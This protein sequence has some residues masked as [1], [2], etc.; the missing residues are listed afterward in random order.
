MPSPRST[1]AVATLL[2]LPAVAV[3]GPPLV[4]FPMS[5][6]DA[7]S[8]PW[9]GTGWHSP[10][11]SYDRARVTTDTVALLSARTPV[12]V[13]METLRRA[14]IYVADDRSLARDLLSTLRKRAGADSRGTADP[15]ALFD[16]GYALEAYRETQ[17]ERPGAASPELEEDGYP[18]V[19]EAVRLRNGDP[20]MQYAAALVARGRGLRAESEEH[21]RLARAAAT[22]GSSLALT[23]AAHRGLWGDGPAKAR[24]SATR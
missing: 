14:A 13:R 23:L 9:G 19:R 20:A 22:E 16:L 3:A 6:G 5:I 24:S 1:L 17:F 4:C 21:L 2:L 11:P 15:L 18:L 7:A 8:L 12:L 10:S